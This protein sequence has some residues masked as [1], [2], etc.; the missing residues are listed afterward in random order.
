MHL[1]YNKE[2]RLFDLSVGCKYLPDEIGFYV[3]KIPEEVYNQLLQD[4]QP[5]FEKLKQ[6]K[7]QIKSYGYQNRLA[8]NIQ[9][10]Y[11]IILNE[12][13]QKY[14]YESTKKYLFS[15][16][17]ELCYDSKLGYFDAV[18]DNNEIKNYNLLN[19]WV[20]FQK[21]GEFNPI[22]NHSGE[23]S[24][25][26]WLQLPYTFEDEFNSEFLS[27]SNTK[28]AGVFEFVYKPV[29]EDIKVLPLNIDNNIQGY[30][31]LFP[32]KLSHTVY[33]FFTSDNYRITLSGNISFSRNIR[34][35]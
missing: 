3:D 13:I 26:I 8:G 29:L 20:N 5:L 9:D 33:P 18:I 2:N 15:E 32:S 17:N 10:E 27:G 1:I 4:V 12:L 14:L 28:K 7:E 16:G 31:C 6:D 11:G 19:T 22:H 21:K 25:V 24:F 35:G 34:P 30:F 23:L